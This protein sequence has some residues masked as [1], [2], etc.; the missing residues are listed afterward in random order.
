MNK[1]NVEV[2]EKFYKVDLHVHS[3]ASKDYKSKNTEDEF[4]K[5]IKKAKKKKLSIIAITDHNSI[6]G[7]QTFIKIKNELIANRNKIEKKHTRNQKKKIEEIDKKLK[8]FTDIL[9]LPGIE[10]EVRE[11]IHMLVIFNES[12]RIDQIV[13]FL[14]DGGFSKDDWGNEEPSYSPKWDVIDLFEESKKYNCILIDA[15]TDSDKGIY[16]TL[17]NSKRYRAQCFSNEQ[18]VGAI[19]NNEVQKDKL[20]KILQDSKYTRKNPLVFLKASDAHCADEVGKNVTWIKLKNLSFISIVTALQYPEDNVSVVYPR[21]K[22]FIDDLQKDKKTLGIPDFTGDNQGNLAK[23]ICALNNSDGGHCVLGFSEMK[24]IIGLAFIAQNDKQRE[25]KITEYLKTLNECFKLIDG[26]FRFKINPYPLPNQKIIFSISIQKSD[27]LITLKSDNI[28]YT[29]EN[30]VVKKLSGNEIQTVIEDRFMNNIYNKTQIKLEKIET[31]CDLV[32]NMF[33]SVPIIRKYEKNSLHLRNLIETPTIEDVFKLND[34]CR[35]KLQN[36][37]LKHRNGKSIGNIVFFKDIQGPRLKNA[38]LRYSVPLFRIGNKIINKK[39]QTIFIIPGGAV[40]YA[41]CDYSFYNPESYQMVKIRSASH[42]K[43]SNAF[44]TCFLKSTFFLWYCLHKFDSFDIRKHEIFHEIMIPSINKK[45]P[46]VKVNV[47]SIENNFN[48][49][50]EVEKEFLTKKI[51]SENI[52][53]HNKLID[54]HAYEI[55]KNIYDLIN[56][57]KNEIDVVES[58]LR[59]NKIHI[60]Q[61]I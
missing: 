12:I 52:N 48:V 34:M 30:G 33:L 56:L 15:H 5:I 50:L 55:D 13:H 46:A 54:R 17:Q 41:N 8:L 10:F 45:I 27:K 37:Y 29:I 16:N 60:P 51:T 57:S 38:Y 23:I 4:L 25:N 9:I 11:G 61:N 7:Y 58:F 18:L 20:I 6:E 49:I 53:R 44:I 59:Q 21:T 14:T 24:N 40:Y 36:Y 31:E 47:E 28:I 2:E 1:M 35:I 32:R 3:P 43:Y 19:Y 26:S 22:K 42:D 39:D